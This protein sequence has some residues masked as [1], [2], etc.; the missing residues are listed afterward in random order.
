MAAERDSHYPAGYNRV[1]ESRGKTVRAGRGWWAPLIGSKTFLPM[2]AGEVGDAF[3]L[4]TTAVASFG[5]TFCRPS[6]IIRVNL[7]GRYALSR[8]AV[9]FARLPYWVLKI[10]RNNVSIR[11]GRKHFL[12]SAWICGPAPFSLRFRLVTVISPGRR[13][14]MLHLTLNGRATSC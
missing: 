3:P 4:I 10:I 6:E 2:R 9:N 8:S 7:K 13:E 1:R 14:K 12:N 11:P 5:R